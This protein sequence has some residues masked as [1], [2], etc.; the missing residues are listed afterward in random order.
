MKIREYLN[1]ITLKDILLVLL[2]ICLGAQVIYQQTHP[3]IETKEKIV[4]RVKTIT[5]KE[6]VPVTTYLSKPML[7][8]FETEKV[9]IQNDTTYI[10]LD[11]EVKEYRDT[12]YYC[13]I[14]GYNPNLEE[15]QIYQRTIE[16]TIE[17]NICK[18]P[19]VSIG[20]SISL[21]YD[22]V[23]KTLSPTVGISVVIPFYSVYLK[24]P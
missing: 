23:N 9:V 13:R 2:V 17:N 12:N 7:I 4:E 21:G 14:S 22:P 15:L 19:I 20:P 5:I 3:Q 6:P 18:K 24:K 10:V 1:N 8:P 16:K 11:R